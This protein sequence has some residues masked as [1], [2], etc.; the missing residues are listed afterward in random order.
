MKVSELINSKKI[1]ISC[2]LFPPKQGSELESS[3]EIVA[4]MAKLKPDFMSVTYGAGGTNCDNSV[5][6]AN[7]VQNVN[8]VTV[9]AHLTCIASE[10][11]KIKEVLSSL[12]EKNIE[13]ILALRGDMPSDGSGVRSSKYKHACDL[14]REIKEYGDFC[15]GGACYPEGHPDADSLEADIASL[16]TKVESGCEFLTTQMFFDNDIMYSFMYKL[17]RAGID[18]PVCAGIMPVTKEKQIK[19][20]CSLSGTHLPRRFVSIVERFEDNPAAMRQAGIAY[21]TEQII[22]LIANGVNNIHIYT[23]NDPQIA[24]SIMQNLSE[25][26]K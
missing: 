18:I 9:L 1:T 11:E 22:D 2:E 7:E 8:G 4:H 24:G 14:M 5:E 23:M 15:I 6:I 16:K 3:K 10:R 25:V 12:K 13:N 20:I 17:L 21:A 19:R 26:I